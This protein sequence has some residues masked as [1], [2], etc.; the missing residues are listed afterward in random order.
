MFDPKLIRND[1]PMYRN[2][3]KMQGHPLVWL[4]NASTTFK[5][6]S[7]LAA[8][9][10]YYTNLTSNSHRGDYD[11]CFDIDKRIL[12]TRETLAR[13]LNCVPSEVVF[14]SGT[15]ASIN[16]VA[17]GYG[18][19][20]L[21]KDDEILLTQAEHASNVLPWYKVAEMTGAKIG[22]IP[23]DKDGRLTVDNLR[24]VIS[25][26]TKIVAVAHVTNVLGYIAPIKELAKVA[27]EYGALMV[28]DGA[29]S[30][31]HI[32]TDVKDLDCDFLSFSGHKLCGPTGIGVLYG[33][34]PLLASTDPFM[35]GGGMNAKF[36]MCGDVAYLEPPLRF[37]A[38]TQNIEGILG[39]KAAVEYIEK[40]GLDNINA[41]EEELKRY[42]VSE[43]EKTGNA[44]IYNAKSEAGIV[45]FNI[46]D[47]FAQ[48][49]ATY[50]NSR[51][52][53][54]RS[55]QHCA[56]ILIDYLGVVAT[57]RASFY[58]YTTKEDVDALVDAVRHGKE[59]LDAYFS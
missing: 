18:A 17:F 33:K 9:S 41:Y 53:A 47:V 16:L 36:D 29:Q 30:V 52:I 59:F 15:T 58:F 1:F 32:P 49:A 8:V 50:L 42:A 11:L 23:L 24:K 43:L 40:I 5:P 54:V 44:I 2:Q 19:K 39:L 14:T 37:E 7:V 34:Y 10:E 56:K 46:K 55:G 26:K 20:Y 21:T 35:T 3:V 38:G 6:D 22:F 13:F 4:D 25:K 28:V 51:G 57:V 48:D 45:T 27:H 12:E 31:P